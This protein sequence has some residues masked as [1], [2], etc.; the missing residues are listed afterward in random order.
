MGIHAMNNY[1]EEYYMILNSAGRKLSGHYSNA[2]RG[3][4]LVY[5]ERD[6][7]SF[8]NKGEAERF[9]RHIQ[10]GGIGMNLR[11]VKAYGRW[12]K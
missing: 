10:K 6:W 4:R 8:G 12:R 3:Q 11:A 1:R 7:Y 5:R 9:I 2:P